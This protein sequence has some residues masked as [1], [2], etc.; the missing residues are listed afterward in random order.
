MKTKNQNKTDVSP[1]LIMKHF[2][3]MIVRHLSRKES[4][5]LILPGPQVFHKTG[6][7]YELDAHTTDCKELQSSYCA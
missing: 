7:L 5:S 3:N 4:V 2:Y 6:K 1:T